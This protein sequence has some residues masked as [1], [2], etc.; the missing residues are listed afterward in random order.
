MVQLNKILLNYL[1]QD[2]NK[3]VFADENGS[4]DLKTFK[5]KINFYIGKIQHF[6]K[7]N[8]L[9]KNSNIG[10]GILLDRN[11]DYFSIIF[12]S[13]LTNCFFYPY[14]KKVKII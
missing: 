9:K 13:W 11:I 10:V 6:K 12:A 8:S 14:P 5:E 7:L 3:I 4:Y 1:D 2:Q